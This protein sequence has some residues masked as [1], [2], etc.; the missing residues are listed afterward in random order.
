MKCCNSL[1]IYCMIFDNLYL[2]INLFKIKCMDIVLIIYLLDKN[3]WGAIEI[4]WQQHIH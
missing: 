3:S 4:E 2:S 1:V